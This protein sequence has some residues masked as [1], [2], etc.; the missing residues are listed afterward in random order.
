MFFF[1][2]IANVQTVQAND[3]GLKKI[4]CTCYLDR[5]ITASGKYTRYGIVSGKRDYLGSIAAIYVYNPDGS[6]GDF[7]GYFEFLDT[8]AGMDSDGDGIGD[9]IRTGK[10]IDVY[11]YTMY[12]AK[13]WIREYGDYVYLKIIEAE[14]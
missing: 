13:E 6:V 1:L 11:Q 14:G 7:I 12:E 5:G 8:G 2:T 10:S 3:S 4:R 9:T